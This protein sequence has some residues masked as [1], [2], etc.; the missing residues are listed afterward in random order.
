M[1]R[2]GFPP[3]FELFSTAVFRMGVF[4]MQIGAYYISYKVNF[5]LFISTAGTLPRYFSRGR[6][7]AKCNPAV[8]STQASIP[9]GIWTLLNFRVLDFPAIVMAWI[10]PPLAAILSFGEEG[11]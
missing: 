9:F 3:P 4:C 6:G 2:R 5:L 10:S 8:E 11:K 7:P 1:V